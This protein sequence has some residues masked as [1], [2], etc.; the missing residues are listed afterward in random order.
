MGVAVNMNIETETHNDIFDESPN[1][2]INTPDK[3]DEI[4][5]IFIKF[6]IDTQFS[7]AKVTNFE[8]R[9]IH[10]MKMLSINACSLLK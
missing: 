8:I 5:K 9:A 10:C 3:D 7:N 1:I 4:I 6:L 2:D